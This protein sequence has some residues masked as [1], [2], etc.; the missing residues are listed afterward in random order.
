ME[1][2]RR[3]GADVTLIE[4]GT[5]CGMGGTFGLKAGP[6]GYELAQ[7][8]GEP[9]F[10]AFKEANIEA[11]VTESSVCRMHLLEGTGLRVYHPLE[12]LTLG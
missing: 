3:L 2:M 8:V 11:I 7:T 6:L 12:L 1:W 9:L 10:K 4:S 5:C